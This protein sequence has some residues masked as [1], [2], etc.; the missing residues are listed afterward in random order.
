[1]KLVTGYKGFIGKRLYSKLQSNSKESPIGIDESDPVLLKKIIDSGQLEE[2]I[3]KSSGVYHIGANSSTQESN[4]SIFYTNY[5]FTKAIVDIA[6]KYD[7]RVVFASSASIYGVDGDNIPKNLYA[8][9]K[10]IC[11]DY[12]LSNYSNFVALRYFNVYGPGEENKGNMA[13]VGYQA[14][15]NNKFFKLFPTR[16]TRD[17]VYIDDVVDATIYSMDNNIK[18]GWYDVGSGKS[19]F[20]E[21]F[22]DA[23]EC[24]FEYR[25]NFELPVGYQ[26]Y[27][28]AKLENMPTGWVPKFDLLTG[29]HEYIK[30][31]EK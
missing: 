10:K 5:E 29:C 14:Y 11:E 20:F 2:L 25:D 6:K 12:G 8:W 7:V 13:S 31:L 15:K 24:E 19:Y 22:L 9:S 27:T 23:M 18:S 17:F 4:A 16:P 21:D 26:T 30:Y 28:R 1:M 3:K